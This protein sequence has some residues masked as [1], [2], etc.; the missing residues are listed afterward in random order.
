[1][2]VSRPDAVALP[3]ITVVTPS[4][5]QAAYV[6]QTMESVHSQD[7]PD[8]EHIVVDG[9]STD[10]SLDIIRRYADR[11]T[12]I[13]EADS[14]QTDAINK[15]LRLAT[16]EIV[17]WLN[18]DDYF[19]PGTLSAVARHF[20]EHPDALWLTGDC[21]IVDKDGA[22]IQQPVR[23]YKRALRALPWQFHLGLTNAITQP[24]TFWRRSAHEQLGY[25][26]E[27][28]HYTMDYDW[29]LRLNTVARPART[30]RALTAFRI[31][32]ESKGGSAYRVQFQEDL[33]VFTRHVDSPLLRRL[34]SLHNK[35]IMR[36]YDRV[37]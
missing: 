26:D 6:G 20:A 31:H 24:A 36:V 14:G 18:S 3:R 10:G 16:G 12:V 5:N 21:V 25:L 29:W 23:W 37:K 34:H 27:S 17:C 2:T 30:P 22:P 33:D 9:L 8:V 7:H 11:A 35:L 15:G 13:S 32:E 19:L 4:Y 1:M 28:L